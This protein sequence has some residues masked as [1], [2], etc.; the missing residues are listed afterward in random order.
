[1]VAE[2]TELSVDIKK[3]DYMITSYSILFCVSY[4]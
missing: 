2:M 1:M 4:G 3:A